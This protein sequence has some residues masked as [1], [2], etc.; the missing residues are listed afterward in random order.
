MIILHDYIH[1]WC[2]KKQV[3]EYITSNDKNTWISTLE[4]RYQA[5]K[6]RVA[7]RGES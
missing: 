3:E 2:I 6:H 5:L 7:E 1:L 4:L